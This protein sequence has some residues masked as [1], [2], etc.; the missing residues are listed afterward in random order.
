MADSLRVVFLA[1]AFPRTAD[2]LTGGFLL[3]LATALRAEEVE[4]VAVAPAAEGLAPTERLGGV[5]VRRYRYA[6]RPAERLAYAGEM[7]RR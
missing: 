6:P 7:H 2:D 3:R 5:E 1:H 4:V